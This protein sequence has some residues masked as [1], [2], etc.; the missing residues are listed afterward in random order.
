VR[1][2]RYLPN[3][4]AALVQAVARIE[5]HEAMPGNR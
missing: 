1:F 3:T 4:F 5:A 2:P